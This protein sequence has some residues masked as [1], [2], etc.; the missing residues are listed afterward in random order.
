MSDIHLN[1]PPP[2]PP[3]YPADGECCFSGCSPCVF[4]RYEEALERYR[5]ELRAWEERQAE[6]DKGTAPSVT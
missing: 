1:D 5:A 4:D 2:V 3:P 6:K